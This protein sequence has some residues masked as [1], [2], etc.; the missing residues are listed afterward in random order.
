M[1]T[2]DD[3]VREA[4]HR[5]EELY[6]ETGGKCCLS[7]S[8]GKDSTVLL[9]LVKM[10]QELYTV[11]D[12][13]AVFSNTGIE[14]GVTVDFVKWVKENYYKNVEIIRPAV[15]FDWVLKNRGKPMK[16]KLKAE[17]LN[18]WHN[19]KR[20]DY[21]TGS[22]IYGE[23]PTGTQTQRTKIADKDLHMIHDNFPIIASSDC[24]KYLK[25]NTFE[26]YAKEN[27]IKGEILGIR[28]EEEGARRISAQRRK[29][30]GGKICTWTNHNRVYKAPIIDWTN[31][32]MEDFIKHYNIPLSKAYTIYGFERTGCMACPFSL[33]VCHDLEYLHDY[34]PNRYKAAMHWLSDV[35][36]AQNVTLPF[37]E[38]YERERE[39]GG[40]RMSQCGKRCLESTGLQAD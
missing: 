9:S 27:G 1:S 38:S 2:L 22:L 8:G 37:D 28:I 34:E 12:I 36:I 7:F 29:K 3:K 5:I 32:E 25:K 35:Y 13:P 31:E 19:H 40:Q 4:C 30:N 10:C 14:L 18:R 33:N 26:T 11:G 15:S 6:Y 17:L 21:V 20:T 39:C 16:S 23:L 24:C